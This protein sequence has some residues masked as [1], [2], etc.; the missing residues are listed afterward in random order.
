[1][2]ATGARHVA[3]VGSGP[4]GLYAADALIRAEPDLVIDI[5]E[6]LPTPFGLIRSGVAP[7]HPGTKAVVRQFEKLFLRP[8]VRFFGNVEVG[9]DVTMH[10]LRRAYDL[11]FVAAGARVDHQLAV[12]GKHLAGVYGSAAFTGWYNGHPDCSDLD[13]AIGERVAI[14]GMGNVALDIARILVRHPDDLAATDVPTGALA[15]LRRRRAREIQ[16]AARRGPLDATFA[17][18]ELTALAAVPGVSITTDTVIPGDTGSPI[19]DRRLAALRDCGT[20]TGALPIRLCF[21]RIPVEILGNG[22][23][24]AVRWKDASSGHTYCEPCDTLITAIGY[25]SVAIEGLPLVTGRADCAESGRI[26]PGLY[27]LGWFRRGPSGTIATNRQEAKSVVHHALGELAEMREREGARDALFR[28]LRVAGTRI[29]DW[30]GWKR[31]EA[32]EKGAPDGYR[33]LAGWTELLEAAESP[34]AL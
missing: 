26:A 14:V 10:A 9:R 19:V 11:L 17:A 33:K 23:V 32:R 30:Q 13:P 15:L 24:E 21:G 1:M 12:P 29:V 2:T 6:R 8:N 4:S 22:R 25:H 3:I 7:D 34:E 27:A 28:A 5:Y 31:I 20:A 18:A 16:L